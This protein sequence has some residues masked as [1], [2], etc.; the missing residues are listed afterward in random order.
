M[1]F[2]FFFIPLLQ[3]YGDFDDKSMEVNE[4]TN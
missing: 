4:W 1:I 3:F 2:A